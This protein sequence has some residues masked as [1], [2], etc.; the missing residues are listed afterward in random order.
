MAALK[1]VRGMVWPADDE[2][3]MSV[4]FDEVHKLE[5]VYPHVTD[6]SA[7]VQA[8][9]NCGVWALALAKKFGSVYTFEPDPANFTCLAHNVNEYPNVY[10]LQAALGAPESAPIELERFMANCGAHQV[11][12]PGAIP[13]LTVDALNLHSCGLL[14]LDIEGFEHQALKGAV[15]TL[16]HCRPVVVL[17][18]KGI[19]NRYGMPDEE[20]D[21]WICAGFKYRLAE[22]IGKDRLYVPL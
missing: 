2:A 21:A 3:C 15:H 4:V 10:R 6:W 1:L 9:G 16:I 11:N 19:G 22:R 12:G 20:L 18:M 5:V 7:C 8:G 17:E 13:V 14:Y